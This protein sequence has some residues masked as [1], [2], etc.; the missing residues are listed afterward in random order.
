MACSEVLTGHIFY[1]TV[2][3]SI[4]WKLIWTIFQH[5]DNVTSDSLKFKCILRSVKVLYVNKCYMLYVTYVR[6]CACMGAK[7]ELNRGI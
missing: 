3:A 1:H 6:V 4:L 5:G 2:D 7:T